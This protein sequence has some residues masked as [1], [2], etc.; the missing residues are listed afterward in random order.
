MEN[1]KLKR[2]ETGA[3]FYEKLP[4]DAILAE[5]P[6]FYDKRGNPIVRMP[7]LVQSF[8]DKK[9]Y[10][11]RVSPYFPDLLFKYFL[12]QDRVYVFVSK[13]N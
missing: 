1:I 8:R 6:M 3:P 12:D 4:K 10:A 9:F 13:A 2:D 11:Y 5:E 7:Y